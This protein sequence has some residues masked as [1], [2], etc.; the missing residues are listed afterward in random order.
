MKNNFLDKQVTKKGYFKRKLPE[1]CFTTSS[2]LEKAKIAFGFIQNHFNWNEKY[3]PSRKV[4]VKKAFEQ[5]TGNIFD[6][7]LSLYN[8]LQALKIESYLVLS[9]TRNRALPIKVHPVINEFNY[10]FV[11]IILNEKV[12]YL[13]ATDKFLPFG[14]VRFEAVNGDGRVLDFEKGSFWEPIAMKTK[15]TESIRVK[16]DLLE[17]EAIGSMKI[18]KTGYKALDRRRE[19]VSKNKEEILESFESKYPYLEIEDF[20]IDN[21]TD[22]EKSLTETYQFSLETELKNGGYIISP[23]LISKIKENPFK[24]N[25]R[26]YPV[27]FGYPKNFTY[28]LS[29][30]LPE[31]Y[32]VK[33]LL[34]NKAL[35]LPNN[36]GRLLVNNHVKNQEYLLFF[37]FS[38]DRSVFNSLEY[39]NLKEFFKEIIKAQAATIEIIRE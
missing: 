12:Y 4:N 37:K 38:V 18:V 1:N 16:L 29:I 10:L 39:F 34:E 21:K 7:N 3:W 22:F 8:A 13:D 32:T 14:L 28:I 15:V 33:K 11:K 24:L 26:D 25:K 23:I 35:S 5:G 20:N 36:G 6:I 31:G 30:K 19:L 17:E 27:D 2:D 9:K